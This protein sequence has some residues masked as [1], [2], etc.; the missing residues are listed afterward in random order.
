MWGWMMDQ[1]FYDLTLFLLR[2]FKQ[3]DEAR[4]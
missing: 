1:N 4:E 2:D 3:R